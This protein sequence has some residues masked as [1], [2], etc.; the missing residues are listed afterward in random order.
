MD[1]TYL[2]AGF[3]SLLVGFLGALVFVGVR[4]RAYRKL[5]GSAVTIAVIADFVLLI[6]WSRTDAITADFLLTDLT[7]FLGYALAACL[8]GT[9]PVLA[10]RELFRW[11]QRPDAE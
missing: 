10:C 8:I 9:L 7:F 11:A 6:D 1:I 2:V 3:L 4:G 5:L